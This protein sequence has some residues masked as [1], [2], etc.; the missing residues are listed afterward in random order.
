MIN[1]A[2]NNEVKFL[3]SLEANYKKLQTDTNTALSKYK[4][5]T[6]QI[7]ADTKKLKSSIDAVLNKYK[8]FKIS[9]DAGSLS[10]V[11]S[12]LKE[13]KKTQ[14]SIKPNKL[15]VGSEQSVI[16]QVTKEYEKLGQEAYIFSKNNANASK[17]FIESLK[18]QGNQVE[19]IRN[20]QTGAITKIVATYRN[21][22]NEIQKTFFNPI[23]AKYDTLNA[24][25]KTGQRSVEGFVAAT[26]K[27]NNTETFKLDIG[28]TKFIDKLKEARHS[29]DI[30]GKEY[31]KLKTKAQSA[32]SS[33][34]IDDLNRK[35][36]QSVLKE[37]RKNQLIATQEKARER[38]NKLEADLVRL[39]NS[40]PRY[41]ASYAGKQEVQQIKSLIEQVKQA[42]VFTKDI[43]KSTAKL[44][45]EFKNVGE[46]VTKVNNA[47]LNLRANAQAATRSTIGVVEALRIAAQRFPVWLIASTA[48][49]G[50]ARAARSL[51]DNVIEL[52]TALTNLRRV[53]NAPDHV[54]NEILDQ[55]IQNVTEL[56]GLL[57][58]YLEIVGEFARQ[59]FDD[60][61]SLSLANTAQLL[62]NI[63]ELKP[64]ESVSALTAALISFNIA[65]EDSIQIADK[66]NE[67]NI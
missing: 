36:D 24:K 21:S 51:I 7:N 17:D 29:L 37:Q 16:K 8:S 62:S 27:I 6:I 55:S 38:V 34:Q 31:D 19:V 41:V 64:N 14:E 53:M 32:I 40:N 33:N 4:D 39:Q 60:V 23:E 11:N 43:T 28:V 59:G 52:D 54:F 66:L 47:L 22:A 58:G 25:V 5:H 18:Q 15:F 67:V 49:Y 13:I 42:N 44:K 12:Q 3:V 48:F 61:E 26:T 63:S 35:L 30:T 1:L 10:G 20:A 65:A 57:T 50:V 9:V 45:T 2:T 46:D 56:S